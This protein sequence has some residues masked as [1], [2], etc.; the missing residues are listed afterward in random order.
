MIT[1]A[2][3]LT[4]SLKAKNA[5]AMATAYRLVQVELAAK[6]MLDAAYAARCA[7]AAGSLDEAAAYLSAID[8]AGDEL[9]SR[10]TSHAKVA[11]DQELSP[12]E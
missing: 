3:Q 2:E 7:Y 8:L 10:H 12:C 6:R 4:E 1:R 9:L 5:P 11:I